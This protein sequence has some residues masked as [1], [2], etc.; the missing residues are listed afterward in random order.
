MN[1]LKFLVVGALVGASSA[2]AA[3]S[4]T[5]DPVGIQT[6]SVGR[7]TQNI[8]LPLLRPAIAGLVQI[9]EQSGNTITTASTD[10]N[11]ATAL[12]SG[13]PYYLEIV[14]DSSSNREIS[15]VGDRFDINSKATVD[16][17]NGDIYLLPDSPNNTVA[18]AIPNLVGYSFLVRPHHTLA[19][20]FG[21]NK[22]A[23]LATANGTKAPADRVFIQKP[24]SDSNLVYNLVKTGTTG[25]SEWRMVGGDTTSFND[26]TIAP[27]TGVQVTRLIK[28]KVTWSIAGDVRT[29]SHSVKPMRTGKNFMSLLYPVNAT[30]AA[31]GFT[32]SNNFTSGTTAAQADQISIWNPK[33]AKFV[34][35][36]LMKN[37]T[38]VQWRSTVLKDR[39]DY[40]S[41]LI[42][43][44]ESSFYIQRVASNADFIF[45]KPF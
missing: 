24:D 28:G 31:L 41:R 21:T 29:T 11:F 27:G 33:T 36:F 15:L 45:N 26:L 13:K 34:N 10:V 19:S 22:T 14:A 4:A 44:P 35:Y 40:T 43:K 20:V 18:G 37:G 17:A 32:E 23:R 3:T 16:S 42:L 7:G 2:F 1:L 5:T 12:E 6:I 30:P 25:T 38:T 8:G 39:R 9:T